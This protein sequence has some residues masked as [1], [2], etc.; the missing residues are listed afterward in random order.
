MNK[1]DRRKEDAFLFKTPSLLFYGE[2][3][4][5]Y[6]TYNSFYY[7]RF[8]FNPYFYVQVSFAVLGVH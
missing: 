8:P 5:I 2:N 7:S 1:R 6:T 4:S 3:K